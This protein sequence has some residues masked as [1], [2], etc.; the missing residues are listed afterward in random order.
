[1]SETQR[2]LIGWFLKTGKNHLAIDVQH[3]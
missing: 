1:M 3:P 2:T